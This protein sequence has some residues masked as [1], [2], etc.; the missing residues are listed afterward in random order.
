MGR[1]WAK[2]LTA[3]TDT[4]V[5]RAAA[6]HR[7]TRYTRRTAI[8]Q[9]KRCRE[10]RRDICWTDD[11]AYAVGL[12]ATDGGLVG[13]GAIAF[14]SKDIQL[15]N[16]YLCAVGRRAKPYLVRGGSGSVTYHVQFGDI[17]LYRWLEAIGICPR[18]SL[19]L[20]AIDVPSQF[21]YPLARGLLD[22][23]GTIAHYVHRP[24]RRLYPSYEYERL[25][26]KFH[27][28]SRSHIE[29]LQAQFASR[30]FSGALVVERRRAKT[31]M[32]VLQFGKKAAGSVLTCLYP[33]ESVP[34][35]ERKWRIWQNYLVSRSVPTV[36]F[37]P[38]TLTS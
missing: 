34:K 12:I 16:T 29:W 17:A 37:E 22:G 5:A 24:T 32:Y 23:D 13:R 33:S 11:L 2:G 26:V 3:L 35:L 19:V 10:K 30:G 9:D 1:G 7:G 31:T 36:G 25:I 28:A 18:K 6:A 14:K 15:I 21:L 20:G 38:T 27:S 8:E 4:R